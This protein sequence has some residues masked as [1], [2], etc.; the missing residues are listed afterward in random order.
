MAAPV[1]FKKKVVAF[2]NTQYGDVFDDIDES[3]WRHNLRWLDRSGLALPL[4]SKL[5]LP[6]NWNAVPSCIHDM[7]RARLIDNGKRMA[8][9]LRYFEQANSALAASSV[10]YCCVKGFSLVPDC[11]GSIDERHQ[12]DL[13]FLIASEDAE[14]ARR[15]I[16]S[17]SYRLAQAEA[18][19]EMRFTRP[20]KK[21]L[22]THA[23]LYQMPE[24]PP[25]ELHTRVWEPETE[26][27]EL[28]ALP[29]FLDDTELHEV[30]G[31]SF[32]RLK[33]AQQ[34]V[35]LL[36]HIF[37]HL[38]SSWCRLLSLY[39]VA[40]LIASQSRNERLWSEAAKIIGHDDGIASACAL[41]LGVVQ[42]AFPTDLPQ[43]LQRLYTAHLSSDSSLWLENYARDWL[44]T[45]PP[46]TKL[47]L[48]VQKQFC[49]DAG[50]WRQYVRRRLLPVRK[51]PSICEDAAPET[52]RTV[53]YRV[54][55]M[56]YSASRVWYHLRSDCEYLAARYRWQH[57]LHTRES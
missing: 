7:L 11:F 56:Q 53:A 25:I 12:V 51:S 15:A 57:L 4:A 35:Y 1:L 43:P 46:G 39:E 49:A 44:F 3:T 41:V 10:R 27:V 36:L 48:L 13:D 28:P 20:W 40:T 29:G 14:R 33:P 16:E 45:D 8:E 24:A 5:Q 32:P 26:A 47:A 42:L 38:L 34:F 50:M 54:E 17:L 30:A 31:V 55:Q 2:L 6:E 22:G 9:M 23:Y 37:R 18:S 19:G 52:A 21:H